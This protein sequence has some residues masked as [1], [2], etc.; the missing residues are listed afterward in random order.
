MLSN[1]E[2]PENNA[3][4]AKIKIEFPHVPFSEISEPNEIEPYLLDYLEV[5]G[6]PPDGEVKFIRTALVEETVYW[7]WEFYSD[8]EKIYA[9]ATQDKY[10]NTGLGCDADY[11]GLTPEQYILGDY[12]ECF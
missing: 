11:Y 8:G 9:T 12:Y 3:E 4:L 7:I 2:I 5:E 6:F 10:G 1:D